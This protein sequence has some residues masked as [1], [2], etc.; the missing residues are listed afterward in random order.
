MV[1]F[2]LH[3][4]RTANL[5]NQERTVLPSQRSNMRV[6]KKTNGISRGWTACS[7]TRQRGEEKREGLRILYEVAS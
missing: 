7:E 5:P 2:P 4:R 3:V 6:L 1:I